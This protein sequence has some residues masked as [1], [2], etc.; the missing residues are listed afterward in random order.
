MLLHELRIVRTNLNKRVL[1]VA[2][3]TDA[4]FFQMIIPSIHLLPRMNVTVGFT[5]RAESEQNTKWE[6][7]VYS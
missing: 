2:T 4:I 6:T 1:H 7:L 3:S 5:E